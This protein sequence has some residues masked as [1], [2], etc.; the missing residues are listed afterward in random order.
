MGQSSIQTVTVTL[1]LIPTSLSINVWPTSGDAP[2][3][4]NVNGYLRDDAGNPIRGKAISIIINGTEVAVGTTEFDGLYYA[5][6]IV[7][8]A[9]GTYDIFTEFL[10]DAEYEGCDVGNHVLANGLP[11]PPFP[12]IPAIA[13]LGVAAVGYVL[14]RRA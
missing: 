6:N 14:L 2:L 10:G 9:P 4:I 8:D 3:T 1:A 5:M 11:I 7:L 12:W 13:L